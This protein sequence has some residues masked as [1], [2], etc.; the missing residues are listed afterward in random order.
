M[1]AMRI[2]FNARPYYDD[3]S[4]RLYTVLK[5]KPGIEIEGVFV[6]TDDEETAAIQ[7]RLPGAE[8]R[9]LN[10]FIRTHWEEGS[11]EMLRQ[12]EQRYDC[13]PVWQVIM[14]DRF[15]VR[16]SYDYVVKTVC[17]LFA[18][19]EQLF[20]PGDIDFY[21]DEAIAT[22]QS[23]IAYLTGKKHGVRYL[24]Q[25]LAR[26]L[27]GTHHFITADPFQLNADF[28]P[29]YRHKDYLP[30]THDRAVRFLRDFEEIDAK[31]EYM[32]ASGKWPRFSL[33]FLKLPFIYLKK[34]ISRKYNDPYAYLYYRQYAAVLQPILF[35]FR[36]L[37]NRRYFRLPEPGQKFVLFPLHFQPEASTCV[38]AAKYEKQ[39]FFIDSLAKSLPSDTVLYVKE[40][41]AFLG[42]RAS[43]FYR[44]LQNYPNVVLIDPWASTRALIQASQAV[45]TLTGTAGWE[46][47][48]LQKPVVVGGTVFY[49]NAPGVMRAEDIYGS[50]ERLMRSYRQPERSEIVLY[51]C[52][53]LSSIYKGTAVRTAKAYLTADNFENL[54]DSLLRETDKWQRLD[55]RNCI[56]QRG[57]ASPH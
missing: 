13:A 51:L 53:Y 24:S 12:Y 6:C 57:E 38:C 55:R 2:C 18:F 27:D 32:A 36:Y 10:A 44:A 7:S 45:T 35:Y 21:Y 49:E 17:G 23:Y 48:L 47:M 52:E 5:Q 46:A 34:R 39:L 33:N 26:G 8:T 31:P 25:M 41:T 54:A 1:N 40:H 11:V 50:Y 30:E 15:L 42:H 43:S 37:F 56:G 14:T 3:V 4:V 9:Q 19:Y 29:G 22:A 20:A 28:D 16:R